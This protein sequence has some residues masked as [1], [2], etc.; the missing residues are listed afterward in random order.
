MTDQV[1]SSFTEQETFDFVAQHLIRQ[2]IRS[3]YEGKCMYRSPDNHKCAIGCLIPDEKYRSSME[4][5]SVDY[6]RLSYPGILP[7]VRPTLLNA[8]QRAHDMNN[9]SLLRCSQEWVTMMRDI[10]LDHDLN[11]QAILH[12]LPKDNSDAQLA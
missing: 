7:P 10:A 1:T 3:I 11:P 8:L 6:F 9:I 5:L 4:G 2:G 12:L